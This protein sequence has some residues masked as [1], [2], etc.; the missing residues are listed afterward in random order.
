MK[1]KVE[2]NVPPH[3]GTVEVEAESEEE[4][5]EK[6]IKIAKSRMSLPDASHAS[7]DKFKIIS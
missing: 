1:Y 4:A 6:A 7:A 5:I 2:Y 3:Q